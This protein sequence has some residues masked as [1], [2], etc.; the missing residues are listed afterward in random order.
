MHLAWGDLE[1]NIYPICKPIIFF[2]SRSRTRAIT[3]EKEIVSLAEDLGFFVHFYIPAM[4]VPIQWMW[5]HIQKADVLI[6][7]HGAALTQFLFLKPNAS[8][9]QVGVFLPLSLFLLI[10]FL[11]I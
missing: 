5:K 7:V 8:F 2:V 11:W 3:N 10:I 1:E 6:G 4:D 9:M